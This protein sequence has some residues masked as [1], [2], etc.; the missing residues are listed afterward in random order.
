M[1]GAVIA[2]DNLFGPAYCIHYMRLTYADMAVTLRITE[3]EIR[4]SEKS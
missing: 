1:V 3:M 4:S 2:L